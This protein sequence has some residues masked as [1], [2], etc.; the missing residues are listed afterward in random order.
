MSHPQIVLRWAW[1]LIG[2]MDLLIAADVL[3]ISWLFATIVT[4]VCATLLIA[5]P[6]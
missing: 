2:V 5:R 4:W 3:H 6:E 1:V